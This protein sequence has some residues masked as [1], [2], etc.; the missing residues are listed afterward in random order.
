ML[1]SSEDCV[2]IGSC[3][4]AGHTSCCNNST[5]KGSPA[6]CYCDAN[7]HLFQDCC[8]D[9]PA[10]C[11]QQGLYTTT[12]N[13]YSSY[14]QKHCMLLLDLMPYIASIYNNYIHIS[15]METSNRIATTYNEN[16]DPSSQNLIDYHYRYL[17][18]DIMSVRQV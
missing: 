8:N 18:L 13:V 7:C 11:S 4:L 1:L 12:C 15:D 6:N 14:S 3:V 2:I 10:D 9:V 17:C 16:S 5:C